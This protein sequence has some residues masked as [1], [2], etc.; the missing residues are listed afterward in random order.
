MILG[1]FDEAKFMR[2]ILLIPWIL[3]AGTNT[4]TIL[5]Y[6]DS[7]YILT[8]T[9]VAYDGSYLGQF[10]VQPGQQRNFTQNLSTTQYKHPGTPDISLTPYRVIWQCASD[11]YYSMCTNV[12]PGQMVRANDCAG[13]RVCQPKPEQK[14]EPPSSTLQKVK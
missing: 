10:S 7:P 9:I 3:L 8:A 11:D 12:G 1:M 5:L 2:F 14:K 4:G 6:N 13:Y